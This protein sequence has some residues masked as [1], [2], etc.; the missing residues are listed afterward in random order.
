MEIRRLVPG[1]DALYRPFFARGI[2]EHPRQFRVG[3]EDVEAM[4]SPLL[5]ETSEDFT[6]G[7]FSEAGSLSG[8][9]SFRRER[10]E[11]MRHKGLLYRM[12]VSAE[13]AGKGVGRALLREAVTRARLQLGLE[14]INLTVVSDNT[15]AI[16]L[17]ETEGFQSFSREAQAIKIGETYVDEEQMVLRVQSSEEK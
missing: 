3:L 5:D 15:R 1:D 8:V 10:L 14:Q 16:I 4:P 13:A 2:T 9:V 12:Y 17:Y 6:L 7:A 11:K